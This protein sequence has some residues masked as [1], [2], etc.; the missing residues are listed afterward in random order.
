MAQKV[1]SPRR[2]PPVLLIVAGVVALIALVTV[3]ASLASSG[4][5]GDTASATETAPVDVSGDALTAL[6][7][8]L[9]PLDP[10]DPAIG[11][12]PPTISGSTFDGSPISI[13]PASGSTIVVFLAHWCPHCQAE[14]PRLVEWIDD[15]AVPA[16]VRVVAVATGTSSER[17]NY[18][19]SAWLDET[20]WPGEVLV[21]DTDGTAAL[22]WGL[23][24]YPYFV[25]V[26]AEGQVVGR[27][28]GEIDRATFEQLVA[29][30]AG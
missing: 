13:D 8:D 4:D 20:N 29:D 15:G 5:S 30:V 22:A 28:T 18:P 23:S 24:A 21:D 25:G 17:D 11:D 9:E 7:S 1:S 10:D 19:P 27:G 6:P 2:V 3:V 12:T 14:V 16:G 26:D